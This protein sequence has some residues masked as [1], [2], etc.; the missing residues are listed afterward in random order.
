MHLLPGTRQR[1][2]RLGWATPRVDYSLRTS[3]SA[4][5][6]LPIMLG[7]VIREAREAAR[8]TQEQL[9]DAA[10]LHRTYISM[11]ERDQR[12]PTVDVLVRVAV[13]MGVRASALVARY[14]AAK[15]AS[16]SSD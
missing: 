4:T 7:R 10:G 1:V 15:G 9:A 5:P 13:A 11:L 6:T 2:S 14:E 16:S 3:H 8:L 12:S